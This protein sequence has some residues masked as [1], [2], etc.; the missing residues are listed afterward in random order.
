MTTRG[1][2]EA[3]AAEVANL[4]ADVLE[5]HRRRSASRSSAKR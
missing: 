4:I 5:S 1:F 3:E 2:G